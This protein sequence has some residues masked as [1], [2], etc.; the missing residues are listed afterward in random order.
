MR[1]QGSG[2][3]T[4]RE[5]LSCCGSGCGLAVQENVF[6]PLL[7]ALLG[8]PFALF[9]RFGLFFQFLLEDLRVFFAD[10]V[11]SDVGIFIGLTDGA[12]SAPC[13]L[14]LFLMFRGGLL[15][16]SDDIM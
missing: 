8:H 9:L 6:G 10:F 2:E 7:E 16:A 12:D 13:G 11:G 15:D 4:P 3:A 14:V 1:E 5:T